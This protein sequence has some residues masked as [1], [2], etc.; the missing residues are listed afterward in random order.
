MTFR[1]D[2][3]SD[4][5]QG[6]RT[7]FVSFAGADLTLAEA[8]V[9]ELDEAGV[10]SFFAPRDISSG[11]NFAVE[12]VRAIASC[13]AVVIL[14]SPSALASPHVRRE[15]SLSIDERRRLLPFAVSVLDFDA[16]AS[17][18]WSYWLSAVQV[19]SL[20]T[21]ADIVAEVIASLGERHSDAA[22]APAPV[23]LEAPRR[24]RPA[25]VRLTPSNLLTAQLDKLP[26]VGRDED[27]ARLEQ[28]ATRD[29]DFDARLLVGGGGQGK[30]RLAH[31]LAVS[32]QSTGWDV[33]LL[34]ESGRG[35]FVIQGLG[36]RPTLL[37]VDYAE[38]RDGQVKELLHGV[39]DD[40]L[41]GP[42]RLLMLARSTS[43]WW[44]SLLASSDA[45]SSLL[46]GATVQRLSPIAI[47]RDAT[48]ELYRAACVTFS[49]E[50]GLLRELPTVAPYREFQSP[51]DL[52]Q[53][54][55]ARTLVGDDIGA[56]S[57]TSRILSHERRYLQTAVR[58]EGVG[59]EV[60]LTDLDRFSVLVSLFGAPDEDATVWLFGQCRR[61]FGPVTLRRL[62]RVY[63]RLYPGEGRS[64]SGLRPDSLAAELVAQLLADDGVL[65]IGAPT[66][67]QLDVPQVRRGLWLLA[68]VQSREA[69]AILEQVVRSGSS[70]VLR[71]AVDVATQLEEPAAITGPLSTAAHGL[72]LGGALELFQLLPEE[73]V[74]LAE[75]AAELAA[76]ILGAQGE[77]GSPDLLIEA[78]NRFSDAG[79]VDRAS[80]AILLA[81]E[82]LRDGANEAQA[83]SERFGRALSSLSN[84]LWESGR[85]DEAVDPARAAVDMLVDAG[86][87]TATI[88]WSRGNLAFR[89]LE[90]GDVEA[91]RAQARDALS[92]WRGG[93]GGH[94]ERTRGLATA[95]NNLCCIELASGAHHEAAEHGRLALSLR[96]QQA[97][98]DRDRYLPYIARTLANAAPAVLA[99]GNRADA[100]QMAAEATALHRLTGRRAPI[101]RYEQAEGLVILGV[102]QAA[103]GQPDKAVDSFDHAAIILGSIPADLGQLSDRLAHAIVQN[104][105]R[106]SHAV[107]P[108]WNE[109]SVVGVSASPRGYLLPV[110]LE[111]RDLA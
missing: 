109:V 12:I 102:M 27:M 51:L 90:V 24:R 46:D 86:A 110:L 65:P 56:G 17:T 5:G 40:G 43:E 63:R 83:P 19:R 97:L 96:K 50:L 29:D 34:E 13:D 92:T 60:G 87:D 79:W 1:R 91:A 47:G 3:A 21:S 69:T 111:Y 66:W 10:T 52:L 16:L 39:F 32:L 100:M 72:S 48:D 38:T 37:V 84:R 22:A 4:E 15:V 53:D 28:W 85:I 88:A 20:L 104:R 25:R 71:A 42:V 49:A 75:I 2:L 74:N 41:L 81:V 106:A 108:T 6:R 36:A 105:E 31:E 95:L 55:L 67:E 30:S 54:A 64:V 76:R 99:A 82:K 101:F 57:V 58:A 77:G 26:L 78:S 94:P 98:R 80:E 103:T 14:L 11:A 62:A 107:S 18:E 61:D 8:V 68:S 7:V 93:L 35:G 89:L 59:D 23:S 73:T 70:R 44:P 45:A 9:A 33:Q